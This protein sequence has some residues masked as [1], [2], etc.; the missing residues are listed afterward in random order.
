MKSNNNLH[1]HLRINTCVILAEFLDVEKDGKKLLRQYKFKPNGLVF[2]EK[3]PGG[4]DLQPLEGHV[5][6]TR[7]PCCVMGD[8]KPTE[9][10]IKLNCGHVVGE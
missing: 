6:L 1:L 7:E 8:N 10:R 2:C 5:S 9:W 4:S 3:T